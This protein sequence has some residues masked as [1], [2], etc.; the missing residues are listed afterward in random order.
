MKSKKRTILSI[1]LLTVCVTLLLGVTAL[2]A[3]YRLSVPVEGADSSLTAEPDY[4]AAYA[5]VAS[6][7]DLLPFTAPRLF[8]DGSLVSDAAERLYI[9]LTDSITLT[10]DLVFSRDVYLDLNGYF[11]D[12]N[13]FDLVICHGYAGSTVLNN[14]KTGG[15]IT[16]TAPQKGK[17]KV[18]TPNSILSLKAGLV[19]A[20]VTVDQT[21]AELGDEIARL[22]GMFISPYR[23]TGTGAQDP[24]YFVASGTLLELPTHFYNF[25]FLLDWQSTLIYPDGR[26]Q[27]VASDTD[28]VLTLR[29]IDAAYGLALNTP[30][31]VRVVASANTF[32]Q[33]AENELS[34]LFADTDRFYS[35]EDEDNERTVHVLTQNAVLPAP[36]YFMAAFGTTVTYLCSDY[37]NLTGGAPPPH[38]LTVTARGDEFTLVIQIARPGGVSR[39]ATYYFK[40]W[41]VNNFEE[42]YKLMDEHTY[43]ARPEDVLPQRLLP[44]MVK[45]VE[46]VLPLP[47]AADFSDSFV[48]DIIYTLDQNDYYSL[49]V[50]DGRAC[51]RVSAAT[52]PPVEE[53]INLVVDMRFAVGMTRRVL[54]TYRVYKGVLSGLE[55]SGADYDSLVFGMVNEA[56]LEVLPYAKTLVT[57][58]LPK[59]VSDSATIA[60][61]IPIGYRLDAY[62]QPL[63]VAEIDHERMD[64]GNLVSNYVTIDRTSDPN[65]V[66]F[67]IEQ[68]HLAYMDQNDIRIKIRIKVGGDDPS[69]ERDYYTRY[70]LLTMPGIVRYNTGTG[71]SDYWV[72]TRSLFDA[73]ITQYQV[74]ADLKYYYTDPNAAIASRVYTLREWIEAPRP[75]N[76]PFIFNTTVNYTFQGVQYLTGTQ[77]FDFSRTNMSMA[78]VNTY[79]GGFSQIRS[80]TLNSLTYTLASI[81]SFPRLPSLEILSLSRNS[82]LNITGLRVLNTLLVLDLSYNSL[83]DLRA[84]NPTDM[85][86]FRYMLG[87]KTLRINNNRIHY[88]EFLLD[89]PF[90]EDI[91]TYTNA[92]DDTKYDAMLGSAGKSTETVFIKLLAA[93]NNIKIHN[94]AT[95][96]SQYINFSQFT[97][98]QVESAH[99]LYSIFIFQ[100]FKRDMDNRMYFP[101][102]IYKS[103]STIAYTVSWNTTTTSPHGDFGSAPT[104]TGLAWIRFTTVDAGTYHIFASINTG[105]GSYVE[106]AFVVEVLP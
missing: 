40:C 52:L 32:I 27:S 82:I 92:V 9:R 48:T 49:D 106:R 75:I 96:P 24:H 71:R 31:R 19:D 100:S 78:D 3:L 25:D 51:I 23:Y 74:T 17:V 5:D 72:R 42:A 59:V 69:N 99:A 62:N 2:F 73:M 90:L 88:F 77:A 44:L 101:V 38:T 35:Y 6:E 15:G 103:T 60:E 81:T 105:G 95:S 46:S 54:Y 91:Y 37:S 89:L 47:D 93:N 66:F 53:V 70:C 30:F 4:T 102:S 14:L 33:L 26:V 18:Y 58:K 41:P 11:V 64:N 22:A 85:T 80:L 97:L 84:T 8:N 20:S 43:F 10:E 21:Y 39:T 67:R 1:G 57:F 65:Y 7:Y 94:N 56:Y 63:D 61:Q 55:Q 76:N 13:G 98:A 34:A 28:T 104:G 50:V 45:S 83:N 16:D 29:V 68:S 79:L 36:S 87:L 86:V 12:L